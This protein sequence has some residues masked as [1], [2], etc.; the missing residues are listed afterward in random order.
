M[1]RLTLHP[2]LPGPALAAF[3]AS[4]GA[5]VTGETAALVVLS[6]VAYR[7]G[8]LGAVG[9]ASALRVLPAIVAAPWGAV[10]TDRFSGARVLRR[11]P[12]SDGATSRPGC[13]RLGVESGCWRH[14]CMRPQSPFTAALHAARRHRQ[15]RL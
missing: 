4:W 13:R 9:I 14:H 8:G 3:A 6:V 12:A 7:E 5:W 2:L 10:L 1:R 15:C 11:L